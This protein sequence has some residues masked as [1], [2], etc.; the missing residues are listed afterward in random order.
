MRTAA[1]LATVTLLVTP[2]PGQAA[3]PPALAGTTVI[4]GSSPARMLVSVPR[5]ARFWFDPAR[6]VTIEGAGR[7]V[8]VRLVEV[9][10]PRDESDQ[11]TPEEAEFLRRPPQ[12]GSTVAVTAPA[13]SYR[14]EC[15]PDELKPGEQQCVEHRS[16]Q[17]RLRRGTYWLY[18]LTDGAPVQVTLRFTNLPGRTMLSPTRPNA[19]T[20]TP[21]HT[22][23]DA[24]QV[25]SSGTAIRNAAV[26]MLGYAAIWWE[27][28]E[29]YYARTGA[30]WYDSDGVEQLGDYRWLP[31]CPAAGSIVS[32][33]HLHTPIHPAWWIGEA[34]RHGGMT[35]GTF[36]PPGTYGIGLWVEARQI[37]NI[38]G[39]GAWL[40]LAPP[41]GEEA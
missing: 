21:M 12:L 26:P 10:R 14:K 29:S 1:G 5:A 19:F 4:T 24:G 31:Y 33:G 35:T 20:F 40:E 18:L 8:G 25:W 37:R 7:L 15:R 36:L 11:A 22:S 23:V 34:G 32:M 17:A 30:C 3:P 9:Y 13:A 16:P 39:F 2:V 28:D 6:S 27:Q 38:G 41:P